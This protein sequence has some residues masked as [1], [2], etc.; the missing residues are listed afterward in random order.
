MSKNAII[1]ALDIGIS[2]LIIENGV[3]DLPDYYKGLKICIKKL[4]SQSSEV[5]LKSWDIENGDAAYVEINPE[6][7]SET[8]SDLEIDLDKKLNDLIAENQNFDLVLHI[9]NQPEKYILRIE[10]ILQPSFSAH[11][12]GHKTENEEIPKASSQEQKVAEENIKPQIQENNDLNVQQGLSKG[13]KIL[14]A[15]IVAL[16][17]ITLFVLAFLFFKGLIF[18]GA[19]SAQVKEPTLQEEVLE[20]E[21]SQN[22]QSK[23]EK[24]S[25]D[26]GENRTSVEQVEENVPEISISDDQDE[27]PKALNTQ[28]NINNDVQSNLTETK[29]CTI[30]NESDAKILSTCIQSKPDVKAWLNLSREALDKGRCDLALRIYLSRGRSGDTEVA[31]EYARYL[32]PNSN[33]SHACFV[34]EQ[35]QAVYWYKKVLEQGPNEEA[36]KALGILVK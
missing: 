26:L 25:D 3:Y 5:S 16:L 36:S 17:L 34:K 4:L 6:S 21:K 27:E 18:S 8:G 23:E 35:N 7:I 22:E 11:N 1:R 15:A 24:T 20:E 10:G 12:Y 29:P 31:L 19:S 13:I 14:I 2:S 32:D 33:Y 9:L 30:V 28:V